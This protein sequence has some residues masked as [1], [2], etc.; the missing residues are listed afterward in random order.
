MPAT[1]VSLLAKTVAGMARSYPA[2]LSW[3]PGGVIV[4]PHRMLVSGE[5]MYFH[6]AGQ[7]LQ[8]LIRRLVFLFRIQLTCQLQTLVAVSIVAS[9]KI[10]DY[11]KNINHNL[12]EIVWP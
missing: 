6:C 4:V 1:T 9:T 12:L 11:V 7:T 2:R 10:G 3:Q 5:F 8:K